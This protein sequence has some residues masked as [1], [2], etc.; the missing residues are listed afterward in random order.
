MRILLTG[1]NG[2]IGSQIAMALKQAGHDVVAGVRKRRDIVPDQNTI[3]V[4]YKQDTNISCWLPRLEG[5]DAV[6]NCVGILR[7]GSRGSFDAVHRDTP[8]ALFKACQEQGI[9]KI[10]QISAIGDS[11]DTD[12]IRSKHK[13]DE[14]LKTL[15]L[16]WVI[17]RPSVVYS[18]RGSYGGTSLI[19]AMAALPYVLFLPGGGLQQLQP[20]TGEDLGRIVL[21]VL[22]REDVNQMTIEAI[23]PAPISFKDFLLSLRRWLKVPDPLFVYNVPLWLIKPVALLGEWFGRGPLGL[24]MYRMLQRGNIGSPGGY[25]RLVKITG[26]ETDS[27]DQACE[28]AP[29]FVQDY[30]HARLY[31]LIPLLRVF[32]GL[33][34]VGSGIVGFMLPTEESVAVVQAL[35]LPVSTTKFIVF[36]AS[37][38]D[39]LLGFMLLTRFYLK[40]A[41]S[42]MLVSVLVY[43][44]TLGI[45]LPELWLEPFGGLIK[46]IP[47]IPA[48]LILL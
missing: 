18:V 46:N 21:N 44:I 8:I 39:I 3:P 33:L 36:S 40:L 30:W 25:E 47:L 32:L 9:K 43:T 34:W 1:A 26:V 41:A 5:V 4:D 17:I 37:S 7:E 29:S 38:L 11:E 48:L 15:D 35:S 23:G 45:F 2:F 27:V 16:D 14:Q 22:E 24:T 10:I 12:F 28:C 31:F 42:L 20:I 13:A 19:R 6:I